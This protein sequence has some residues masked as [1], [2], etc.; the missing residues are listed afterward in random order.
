MSQP[1][2]SLATGPVPERDHGG[3]PASFARILLIAELLLL[4]CGA[5]YLIVATPHL[6]AGYDPGAPLQESAAT[7]PRLGLGVVVLGCLWELI[8]LFRG[9]RL[10]ETDEYDL[11]DSSPMRCLTALVAMLLY[12]V[13]IWAL[14]Y[15]PASIVFVWLM[16]AS[17]G[18]PARPRAVLAL[19]LPGILYVVFIVLLHVAV[20]A[21]ILV[22]VTF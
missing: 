2:D 11:M 16:A 7:M 13:G 9:A 3:T 1:T 5:V 10:G 6:V 17:A 20:P 14:G 8:R 15:L 12:V 18:I 19:L 22:S 21:G 4:V